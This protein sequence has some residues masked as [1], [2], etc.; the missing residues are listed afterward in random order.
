MEY[1]P[2]NVETIAETTPI[3]KTANVRLYSNVS[4]DL[5]C[6]EFNEDIHPP[7]K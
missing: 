3:I 1:V 7:I 5:S 6:T 4:L 2:K